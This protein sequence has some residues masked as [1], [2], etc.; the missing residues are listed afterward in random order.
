[1]NKQIVSREDVDELL[2][3][4]VHEETCTK[5]QIKIL[6][7]LDTSHLDVT[8]FMLVI[9]SYLQKWNKTVIL[10]KTYDGQLRPKDW[11]ED[12]VEDD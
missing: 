7:R 1:M 3:V 2:I 10:P 8:E 5:E 11:F 4:L 9:E 6:R 12:E